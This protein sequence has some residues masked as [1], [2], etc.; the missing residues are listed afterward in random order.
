MRAPRPRATMVDNVRTVKDLLGEDKN[1]GP[2]NSPRSLEAC[3]RKGYDPD[4]L[5]HRCVRVRARRGAARR[6]KTR[7]SLRA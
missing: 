2:I 4:E 6:E 5:R 7:G 1:G 3:L